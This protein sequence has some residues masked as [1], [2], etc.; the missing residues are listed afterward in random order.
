MRQ[1]QRAIFPRG[2]LSPKAFYQAQLAA[3][4]KLE[5][6]AANYQKEGWELAIGSS[7]TIKAIR[8]VLVAAGHEDGVITPKRL[9]NLV[10]ELLKFKH[11]EDITLPG[12]PPERQPVFAAGL[13]ILCGVFDALQ[14][15]QMEFSQGALREG[16]LYE[17]EERFQEG[18]IRVRTAKDLALR[19]RVDVDHATNVEQ[20]ASMLYLKAEPSQGNKKSELANLLQWGALLHEVG[21]SIAYS[22]F[23][24]HSYY[25]L[26]NAP[27]PGFSSEQRLLVATLARFHRKALKLAE[28]PPFTLYKSRH[29]HTLIAALRIACILNVQRRDIAL[30]EINLE[31]DD[32]QWTLTFPAEWLE[33]NRLLAA[34]LEQ[35]QIYW[36]NAGWKLDIQSI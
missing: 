31:T 17:V 8:E 13:A 7:G 2:K 16:L 30:P 6:I 15:E 25:I 9:K 14:I 20:T 18:D 29:I 4:L 33:Q 10:E 32:T 23:H 1:L 21:L 22:G 28:M 36:K 34:D 27:M 3:E 11:F 19:Y 12:L 5:N 26:Q 24:K 35:E